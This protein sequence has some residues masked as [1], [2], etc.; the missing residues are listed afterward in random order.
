MHAAGVIEE[1]ANDKTVL[2]DSR[3][4]NR[5]EMKTAKKPQAFRQ[6]P[7]S[8]ISMPEPKDPHYRKL[9]GKDE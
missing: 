9:F 5:A 3:P 1:E 6:F 2:E 4:V 7:R 8:T